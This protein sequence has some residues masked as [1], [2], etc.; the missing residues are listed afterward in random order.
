MIIAYIVILVFFA[1]GI[2]MIAAKSY[3]IGIIITGFTCFVSIFVAKTCLVKTKNTLSIKKGD[4]IIKSDIIE[5]DNTDEHLK[6]SGE[7]SFFIMHNSGKCICC[8]KVLVGDVSRGNELYLFYLN[9]PSGK[10]SQPFDPSQSDTVTLKFM[11]GLTP[12]QLEDIKRR[13]VNYNNSADN[14]FLVINPSLIGLSNEILEK[15]Q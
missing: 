1:V 8:D 5:S 15:K 2:A 10:P 9:N 3:L 4:Y 7:K 12:E 6:Y 11:N 13:S 14:P